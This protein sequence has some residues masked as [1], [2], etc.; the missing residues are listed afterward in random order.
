MGA[1]F[2]AVIALVVAILTGGCGASKSTATPSPASSAAAE[3][4]TRDDIVPSQG[5][6]PTRAPDAVVTASAGS[7][8]LAAPAC[9]QARPQAAGN[10][11]V[12]L[13]S[14]RHYILH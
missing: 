7:P 13:D 4:N 10:S 14:G 12:T 5:S 3:V 1:S 9:A 11:D 2:V 6:T 8:A